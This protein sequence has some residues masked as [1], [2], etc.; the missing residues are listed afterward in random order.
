MF[1]YAFPAHE[2]VVGVVKHVGAEIRAEFLLGCG[3]A[4][5][6]MVCPIDWISLR[7]SELTDRRGF[8]CDGWSV[9]MSGGMD[10]VGVDGSA[11]EE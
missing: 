5:L 9:Q 1:E 3:A 8:E 7:D 2:A 6:K 4:G 10:E 11:N